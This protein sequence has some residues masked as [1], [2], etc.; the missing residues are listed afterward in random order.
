MPAKLPNLAAYKVCS[1]TKYI[2]SEPGKFHFNGAYHDDI[3]EPP[4][5][6]SANQGHQFANDVQDVLDIRG[7]IFQS[8]DGKTVAAVAP[9]IA[10]SDVLRRTADDNAIV[11]VVDDVVIEQQVSSRHVET[12]Q[13]VLTSR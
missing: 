10:E 12:Y 4:R 1:C 13:R 7:I 8:R 6:M 2:N 9:P 3:F 5:T 11:L